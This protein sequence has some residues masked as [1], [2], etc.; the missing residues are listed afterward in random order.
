MVAKVHTLS[1]GVS[2]NKC[3]SEQVVPRWEREVHAADRTAQS[4]SDR[5]VSLL[6][7]WDRI[8]ENDFDL[9]AIVAPV[10]RSGR[11]DVNV[12]GQS[13]VNGRVAQID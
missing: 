12:L 8:G 4:V 2:Y 13:R 6:P 7:C 1:L 5:E 9:A 11:L 10:E 3:R